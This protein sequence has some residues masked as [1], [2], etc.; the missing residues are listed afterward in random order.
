M[1]Y[2]SK[3]GVGIYTDYHE[4]IIVDSAHPI[5]EWKATKKN[6]R[7]PD[8]SPYIASQHSEDALSWNVFRSLQQGNKLQLV[9]DMV[10]PGIDIDMVYF[11]QH[12]AHKRSQE[13]DPE[14]QDVLNEIEPWGKNRA[15]QQ[16]ETDVILRGKRDTILIESKLGKPNQMV[17]AWVRSGPRNRPMRSDYLSFMQKLGVKLFNDSF[18]FE[19]DGRRFYQLFRNYVLGA[20]FSQKWHTGF[21]VLAIVNSLNSNLKGRTHEEEIQSFQR[22]LVKPSNVFLTTWQQIWKLLPNEP[23]LLRLRQWLLSHPLLGLFSLA[24]QVC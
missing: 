22:L 12:A 18:D 21:S 24:E 17:S 5:L 8:G 2:Y 11:W 20:A 23:E 4:N 15:K 16:T 3:S 13:I 19:Q 1:K 7:L 14:I 6:E 9:T 10:A